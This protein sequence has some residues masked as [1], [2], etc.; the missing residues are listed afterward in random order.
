MVLAPAD[1]AL[2]C[3]T[4][5]AV[6]V[7][8]LVVTVAFQALVICWPL[9][10]VTVTVHLVIA[11]EPAVTLTSPWKP[12]G[13]WPAS[14][15]VAEQPPGGGGDD[16]GETDGLGDGGRLGDGD[17]DGEGGADGEADW[18]GVTPPKFTS[19]QK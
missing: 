18:L 12:P 5:L 14:A 6:A 13:H 17:A 3:A 11:E 1:S 2:L 4:L 10:Q 9:A 7:D 19:L 8:P 15:Y 16:E